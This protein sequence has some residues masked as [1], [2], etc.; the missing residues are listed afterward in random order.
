MVIFRGRF[1]S[2]LIALL[3]CSFQSAT[4]SPAPKTLFSTYF[5]GTNNDFALAVAVDSAGNVYITGVTFSPFLAGN[6]VFLGSS[7]A[8]LAKFSPA[9]Q[10]LYC[11]RIGGTLFDTAFGIAVDSKG[12][13]YVTGATRSPDFLVV[14]G[15][16]STLAGGFD[17]AFLVKLDPTGQILYSTFLGGTGNEA[18]SSIAVDDNG[19]AYIVGSTNSSDFPTLN[20][21]QST[22]GADKSDVFVAKINTN[23]SGPASL[24][25][26]TYIGGGLADGGTG[27]AI[28]ASGNAYI[29]GSTQFDFP[30]TTDAIQTTASTAPHPFMTKLGPDGSLIYSTLLSGSGYGLARA[31]AV[32]DSGAV[33]I[34]GETDSTDF[35]V[36]SNA[37]Q[38]ASS[39]AAGN[40]TAFVAKIDPTIPGTG[41]LVFSTYLGGRGPDSGAGIA[42]DAAKRIYVTGYT[43][44]A[45][46]PTLA[47][48][49]PQLAGSEDVF[50]VEFDLTEPNGSP[51]QFATFLG[52]PSEDQANGMSLASDKRI[53][54]TG[55]TAGGYPTSG[56]FQ[57]PFAGFQDAFVTFVS[58]DTDL[59]TVTV[60]S[61]ITLNATSPG[62]AV[63]NFTATASDESQPNLVPTCT[64]SSGSTFPI[65]TNFDTCSATDASGNTGTATF[66]VSVEGAQDQISDLMRYISNLFLSNCLTNSLDTKL[67]AATQDPLPGACSDMNDLISQVNAHAG[68]DFSVAQGAFMDTSATRIMAVLGCH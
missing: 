5:G 66:I 3:L 26:S 21:I 62:G 6:C 56:P 31:I 37:F 4:A 67:R 43:A 42:V 20:A 51:L 14:N 58:L 27:I 35:P 50:L 63:F 33:Y 30:V 49:Q 11:Q 54:L 1:L 52:G 12:N 60:P 64:L 57:I 19:T 17:D 38:S 25:Y 7:G 59:P 32:D 45:T 53:A 18:G 2:L 23:L 68:K 40:L 36:T 41:G 29:T 47:A 10:L 24:I 15:F 22:F 55:F 9:G 34:T 8:F 48:I 28:D 61:A 44:S 65:G 13:V 16:Q 46:F 39:A